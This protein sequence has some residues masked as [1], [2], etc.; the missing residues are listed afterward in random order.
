MDLRG[1]RGCHPVGCASY[2]RF[3]EAARLRARVSTRGADKAQL[4][5]MSRLCLWS[6]L[7]GW[8][9]EVVS[10][11]LMPS[12]VRATG[13]QLGVDPV[14]YRLDYL[15]DAGDNFI[16][17]SLE[18]VATGAGWTRRLQLFGDREGG[19]RSEAREEGDVELPPAGGDVEALIG[20]LDC[21]LGFSPLTNLMPVRRHALHERPGAV[22]LLVAWVSVPDL[23]L[24]ASHQRY[25]HV[26]RQANEAVVRYIDLG[27]HRGF[28]SEL[29]LD[30]DGLVLVY[31]QLARRV[32]QPA[33]AKTR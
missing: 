27:T 1:D 14:P 19:W 8:R 23:G 5:L 30:N 12:G 9:A 15:L 2:R 26:R 32:D 28:T 6:G 20:A 7:D 18:V 24:N 13:T 31:P 4:A 21:D 22:D 25:E 16:T 17:R 33:G 11:N 29:V 10:V 3:L